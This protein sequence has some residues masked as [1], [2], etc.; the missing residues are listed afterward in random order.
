MVQI[1]PVSRGMKL[2]SLLKWLGRFISEAGS[3]QST[4]FRWWDSRTRFVLA[5]RLDLNASIN[6]R[7]WDFKNSVTGF[8]R[9]DLNDPLT[10]VRG[11]CEFSPHRSG[12]PLTPTQPGD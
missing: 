4:N 1:Q 6:S 10:P 8:S 3:E 11:I 9:L 5:C 7:W 2:K 12:S